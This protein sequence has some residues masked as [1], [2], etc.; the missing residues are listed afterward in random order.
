MRLDDLMGKKVV[1]TQA[2][3]LGEVCDVEFDEKMLQ[4]TK[5]C[6]KLNDDAAEEMGLKKPKL[7]S[8]KVDVPITVIKAIGDVIALDKSAK[9]LG[10]IAVKR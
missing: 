6:V 5:I 2:K 9:E 3:T 10:P 1:G 8:V 4:L 7:G